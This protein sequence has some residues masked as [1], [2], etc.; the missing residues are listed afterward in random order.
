M[1]NEQAI[2]RHVRQLKTFY[3]H[4]TTYVIVNIILIII[5][6]VTDPHHLW[7]YWVLLFWGIALLSQAIRLFGPGR[8]FNKDWEEKKVQEYMKK[9]QDKNDHQ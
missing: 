7:F 1:T 4:L 2:R 3:Q 6:L 8:K 5:N 9:H